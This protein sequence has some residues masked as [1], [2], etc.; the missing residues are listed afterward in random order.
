MVIKINVSDS[1]IDTFKS[2]L[3][4]YEENPKLLKAVISRYLNDC[5]DRADLDMYLAH[6]LD[7]LDESGEMNDIVYEST[8]E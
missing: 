5:I 2:N 4:N 6:Y 1:V 3:W 7:N 8:L